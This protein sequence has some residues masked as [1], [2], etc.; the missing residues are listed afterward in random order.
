VLVR[1]V[2]APSAI[3]FGKIDFWCP[4]H[5]RICDGTGGVPWATG[6][7]PPRRAP[8]RG[9]NHDH[10]PDSL[11]P[12]RAEDNEPNQPPTSVLSTSCRPPHGAGSVRAPAVR[13][14][15]PR[16]PEDHN[17]GRGRPTWGVPGAVDPGRVM[18]FSPTGRANRLPR[19]PPGSPSIGGGSDRRAGAGTP[20]R[21]VL[22][23]GSGS[24][25]LLIPRLRTGDRPL[26]PAA[27]TPPSE[28]RRF[29]RSA[30]RCRPFCRD[31]D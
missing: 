15:D 5:A 4:L 2:L 27:A 16:L 26:P 18:A 19:A 29:V 12:S 14:R 21:A 8:N 9:R 31:L 10:F 11:P 7:R 6:F 3:I 30:T 24:G 20:P 23:A 17:T 13:E 22:P 1:T 28:G 25:P